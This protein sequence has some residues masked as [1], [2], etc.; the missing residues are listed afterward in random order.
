MRFNCKQS[1]TSKLDRFLH[2]LLRPVVDRYL[3]TAKSLDEYEF[4]SRVHDHVYL[5]QRLQSTTNFCRITIKNY[6]HFYDHDQM[7][8][9]LGQFLYDNLATNRIDELSIP[10]IQY[11][12]RLYLL[13]NHFSYRNDI[14]CWRKGSPLMHSLTHL[15]IHICIDDWHKRLIHFVDIDKEIVVRHEHQ[16]FLT[17]NKDVCV[18]EEFL[19]RLKQDYTY[20]DF[21]F[22]IDTEIDFFGASIKNYDGQLYTNIADRSSIEHYTM[23]YVSKHSK[24][25]HGHWLIVSLN[26][27][28]C[29][30]SS[31]DDFYRERVYLEMTCL[32][33][34]Y[35]LLFIE[36]YVSAFFDSIQSS[37]MRYT[38]EQTHYHSFR[39]RWFS[40]MERRYCLSN[41]LQRTITKRPT[42]E[43][44]Y[45]YEYGPRCQF[46]RSIQQLWWTT[47]E[48]HK[49]LSKN[50]IDLVIRTRHRRSLNSLLCTYH[51]FK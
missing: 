7:I 2:E 33:N 18:L 27:A 5:K 20:I 32:V 3:P 36:S 48:Q 21:T 43:L 45:D 26:R 13:N 15:L 10:T 46:N 6:G 23:P 11:L 4:M 41:Q 19:V 28:V 44:N 8:D 30:C 12:L 40:I 42:I 39:S 16:L 24:V 31:V 47:F 49:Q 1:P 14:Y 35:S 17:W 9:R 29:Y 22:Q 51:D 37:S 50:Q 38:R 25:E 34:G